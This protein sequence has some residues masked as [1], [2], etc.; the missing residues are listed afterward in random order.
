MHLVSFYKIGKFVK[1]KDYVEGSLH[2]FSVLQMIAIPVSLAF[3]YTTGAY[4]IKLNGSVNYAF[5]ITAKF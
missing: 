5:V 1:N 2:E 4:F 3:T